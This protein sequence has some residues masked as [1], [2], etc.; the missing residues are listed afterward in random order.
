LSYNLERGRTVFGFL[1]NDYLTVSTVDITQ[2]TFDLIG[3]PRMSL[4]ELENK[5]DDKVWDIYEK[6]LTCT[7][8]Q[9]DS[10]YR[11]SLCYEI[12]T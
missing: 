4:V 11:N 3:I 7:V 10:I 6:G 2:K 1:K 9:L 8:N 5:L 12:Q